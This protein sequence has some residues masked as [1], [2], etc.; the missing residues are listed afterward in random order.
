M[1]YSLILAT[2]GIIL[3]GC[4]H[5]AEVK[6][7]AELQTKP[8]SRSAEK[9]NIVWLITEDNSKHYLKLYDE[10]G[11]KMPTVESLAEN[12]L[13]FDNAFSNS[14]VCS[15]A[16]TTLATGLYGSSMGTMNHRSYHKVTLPD[17][18]KPFSQLLKQAGYYTTNNV[19]TDYN[20]APIPEVWSDSSNKANWKNRQEGQPFFHMQTFAI[21][22]E[23]KLHFK[24]GQIQN[25][26]TQ[27]DPNK[28]KLAP[29]YP[30]TKT[31]RYT[32]ARTLDNH[33]KADSQ[34]ANV[35]KQLEQDGELEN[36]FI[37]Y[38]GDHG[39]VLPGS[40]GYLFESGLSVPL[41]V[42]V[43]KN[44]KHLLPHSLQKPNT[45]VTGT[46]SF[47][48]FAPTVLEL[49][50]V[51]APNAY[52]GLSFL[53]K[54]VSLQ[55]L[56]QR[57]EIF[58][59]ADRFDEKSDLVRSVR[60]GNLKYI[61]N[62]QP[63][64]PDGLENLY[65]YKQVAF[66]EWRTLFL[67]GKLT[68]QQAAFFLPKKVEALY[69]LS[70]DP[71]EMKNL[72][73]KPEYQTQLKQLRELL[74][75]HQRNIPDLGFLAE[76][77]LVQTKTDKSFYDYGHEQQAKIKQL[78]SVADLQLKP[79]SQ[80]QTQ[81]I[82]ALKHKDDDVVYRAVIVATSFDQQAKAL[83]PTITK[84]LS[85]SHSIQVRSRAL[86][87]LTMVNGFDP[88]KAFSS[89][90]QSTKHDLEKVELLNIATLLKEQRGF[91]FEQPIG[92][93]TPITEDIKLAK[94]VTVWLKNRWGF[95]SKQGY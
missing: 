95:I 43:P 54:E 15:T 91:I 38:F 20:F 1:L 52:P 37:F 70:I 33:V 64:Y 51:D 68:P 40:K 2:A 11:A 13:I 73:D 82:T 21:T 18:V 44:F 31:F 41:V 10:S 75:Q 29:I 55:T 19:K 26:A 8:I 77:K 86:E 4:E 6:L 34:M 12:G 87:F 24:K 66:Q 76:S 47:I 5:S 59:E 60:K 30:D 78:I 67:Q 39:G 85:N 50:G 36:T 27:H 28:V 90:Y 14:P 65:R 48:D 69:D 84:L 63:F 45:R 88:R 93:T 23:G 7:E 16:R 79:Y 89:L 49:A 32:H 71:Y 25:V 94:M 80:I 61:R 46:V 42:R 62:Y 81:L 56:N 17:S 22:H 9:P 92:A 3:T 72:A 74:Q 58:G 83:V 57:D 35:I 53:S